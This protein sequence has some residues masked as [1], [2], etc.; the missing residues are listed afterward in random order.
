M[1]KIIPYILFF[2]GLLLVG[3]AGFY[4]WHAASPQ[5]AAVGSGVS[6]PGLVPQS[7]AGL[8]LAQ[9]VS[10]QPAIDSFKQLI[11]LDFP[12]GSVSMAQYGQNSATL[13]LAETESDAK[14]LELI[15]QFEAKIAQGGLPISPMGVF[16]FQKRKVF[17][18]NSADRT[19]F[20]IQSGK[21]V[22]WLAILPEQ[23]ETAMKE[24][25]AFYP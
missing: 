6:A 17:M 16:E 19:H 5:P 14:A 23:T 25:L 15:S 10:G 1:K 13:W 12:P 7:M 8:P 4:A 18:L 20:F 3:G 9:T 2:V 21:N 22:F 24:L 11:G